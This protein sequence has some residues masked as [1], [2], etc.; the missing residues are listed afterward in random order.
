[1]TDYLN[2]VPVTLTGAQRTEIIEAGA[3]AYSA[4]TVAGGND[5][6]VGVWQ[7]MYRDIDAV[8]GGFSFLTTL[9]SE[10]LPAQE[11]WYSQAGYV[12]GD[13]EDVPSGYF[14]RD[15]TAIGMN[16]SGPTNVD[17]QMASDAVGEQ[18]T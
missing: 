16:V 15:V 9:L 8:F 14:V 1:M 2:S 10:W 6:P 17:V 13:N 11:Y 3:A 18:T 7:Q 4:M 12:N 5:P